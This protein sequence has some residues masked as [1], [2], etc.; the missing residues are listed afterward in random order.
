AASLANLQAEV[1]CLICL[2][3]L[4]NSVT[5]DCGHNFCC[6]CIHQCWEGLEDIFPC[7]TCLHHCYKENLQ[8]NTQLYH[9]T[10]IVKQ[11]PNKRTKRKWQEEKALC[12]KHNQVLVL[13]CEQD[14]E[15]LCPQCRMSSDH[16]NHYLMPIEQA[17]T[18]HR[19]KLKRYTESLR[20]QAEDAED[21]LEMQVSKLFELRQKVE[22]LRRELNE[23][24]QLKNFLHQEWDAILQ[25]KN[26]EEKLIGNNS[27]ISDHF[28]VLKNLL[29]GAAEKCVWADLDLRIGIESICNR[30]KNLKTPG[31]IS[32]SKKRIST[33]K[34]DLTLDPETVHPLTISEDR[35]NIP[36]NPKRFAFIPAVLSSE[37][38]DVGRYYCICKGSFPRNGIMSP[39]AKD[40]CWQIQQATLI[41]GTWD[42]EQVIRIGIF[43]DYD[44]GEVLF[45][46]WDNRSYNY[47]IT[48]TF[49]EKPRPYF[50]LGSTS[51]S[52]TTYINRSTD[53]ISY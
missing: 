52:L 33:F 26:G 15:L 38:C 50:S 17:G 46:S 9:I 49:T 35:K 48:V 23:F 36:Y 5:I 7:P 28:S 32:G 37:G 45:Y 21:G 6:C 22:N 27:Q 20:E 8:N 24:N 13:F 19:K 40:G 11:L 51:N 39:S 34:E 1:S 31:N 43:L 18:S 4:R 2:E 25:E 30:C 42:T 16:K 29:S 47:T 3:Y 14:L 44:L 41:H 12:G 53:I 10:D